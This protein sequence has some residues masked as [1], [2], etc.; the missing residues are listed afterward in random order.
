VD[1][2]RSDGDLVAF[3]ATKDDEMFSWDVAAA[4]AD[5]LRDHFESEGWEVAI[6]TDDGPRRRRLP[7]V[8]I[9]GHWR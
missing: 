5:S 7:R 9:E 8:V 4:Q 2:E 1:P 6:T 3:T